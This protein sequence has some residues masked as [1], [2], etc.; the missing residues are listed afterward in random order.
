MTNVINTLK[1]AT[2][3]ASVAASV[4]TGAVAQDSAEAQNI[5]VANSYFTAVQTGD[6]EALG[7]LV[8]PDVV[9]HQPG[10]NQFSGTHESAQA[11][12]GMIG[13]MMQVSA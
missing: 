2:L 13:G 11:V 12:F 1:H 10:D 4:T 6:L 7:A 9:W 8:A 3:A 5:A